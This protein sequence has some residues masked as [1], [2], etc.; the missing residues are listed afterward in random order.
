MFVPKL[1][2]MKMVQKRQKRKKG[3][4]NQM[5]GEGGYDFYTCVLFSNFKNMMAEQ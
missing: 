3:N 2:I 5:N 1:I 4:M